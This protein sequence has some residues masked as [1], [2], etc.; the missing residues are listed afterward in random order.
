MKCDMWNMIASSTDDGHS[1][2][3]PVVELKHSYYFIS[4]KKKGEKWGGN[5]AGARELRTDS[6]M[7]QTRPNTPEANRKTNSAKAAPDSAARSPFHP[8]TGSHTTGPSIE[9]CLAYNKA[10]LISCSVCSLHVCL[11]LRCC[12]CACAHLWVCVI[13]RTCKVTHQRAQRDKGAA[14]E[15]AGPEDELFWPARL[16]SRD[17]RSL[18][19]SAALKHLFH[20]F[21]ERERKYPVAR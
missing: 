1:E 6:W 7:L 17:S 21:H 14:A 3:L 9:V 12:C 2:N 18:R 13:T 15:A 11:C 16:H 4:S 5:K 8:F 20:S 19:F 10:T